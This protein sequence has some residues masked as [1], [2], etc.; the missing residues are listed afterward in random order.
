MPAREVP[1][2]GPEDI[3]DALLADAFPVNRAVKSVQYITGA[4]AVLMNRLA[5]KP[6]EMPY[7][8]GTASADAWEA[9]KAEGKCIAKKASLSKPEPIN[10]GCSAKG[11]AK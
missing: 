9:G 3:A 11:A 1:H 6:M 5:G 7:R 8:P 2:F 4:R 10:C